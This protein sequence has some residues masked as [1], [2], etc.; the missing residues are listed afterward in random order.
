MIRTIELVVSG[1]EENLLIS[2]P[3]FGTV[4]TRD[5]SK[6]LLFHNYVNILQSGYHKII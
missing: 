6:G 1:M 3:G 5:L 4:L 2:N